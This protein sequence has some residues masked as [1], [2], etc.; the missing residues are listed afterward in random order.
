MLRDT[1][2]ALPLINAQQYVL[3]CCAPVQAYSHEEY[4]MSEFTRQTDAH[5]RALFNAETL[6]LWIAFYC[7]FYGAIMVYGV[8]MFAVSQ[9]SRGGSVVGLAFSNT[10]QLLVF[11]TWTVRLITEAIALSSS[12]EQMTWLAYRTPI[13][14]EDDINNAG[15]SIESALPPLTDVIS[16]P[17]QSSKMPSS[18]HTTSAISGGNLYKRCPYT[19]A[20]RFPV[21]CP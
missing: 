8:S 20:V 21:Y 16:I 5:H 11:Y 14:G 12:I 2:E 19:V 3:R 10:I 1:N 9:R 6:N 7:D 17:I 13:D 15:K 4:F 18:N